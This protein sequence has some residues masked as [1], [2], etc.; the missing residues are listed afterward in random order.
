[1]RIFVVDDEA[2]ITRY[3][4]Q[5]I[6]NAPGKHEVVGTASSGAKALEK[7]GELRPDIL[8]TDITMPKM[9]GLEL[10]RICKEQYP[11]LSVMMLTCH[12]DFEYARQAM[13]DH[14]DD[15]MLKSEIGP[16]FI[17]RKLE[18]LE[19]LRKKRNTDR[20][21]DRIKQ[22]NYIRAMTNAEERSVY[23][24]NEHDLRDSS[25]LLREDAFSAVA[26]SNT[27]QNVDCVLNSLPAEFENFLM[28]PYNENINIL[29]FNIKENA[30]LRGLEEKERYL[31]ACLNTLR[32]RLN[33]YAGRSR[34]FY[35]LAR[36]PMAIDESVADVERQYYGASAVGGMAVEEA[37]RTIQ[38]MIIT[39]AARAEEMD[40]SGCTATIEELL[41][42]A[43]RNHPDSTRLIQ[44]VLQA[45]DLLAQSTEQTLDWSE[46][47]LQQAEGFQAMCG[48]VRK[49]MGRLMQ[50]QRRRY[51]AA[52]GKAVDY[53]GMH[54]GEDLTLNTVADHVFLNREHLS[55]QF[56]KEVGVNFSEYLMELRLREALR[57]LRGTELRI[58]EIADRVGL[59]N[60][61][62]FTSVFKKQYHMTPSEARK[63]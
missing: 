48:L 3:I 17:S 55:R 59:P 41:V 28:Y 27:A 42:F 4:V 62:Y 60:V 12:D 20:M 16:E 58:G 10:L 11:E 21:A 51:S 39:V 15:Y 49:Q 31:T 40:L 8:F 44:T 14:A 29:F 61:S 56:K 45:L 1:M 35:R 5:C 33:G 18:K 43:E 63:Q 57:L 34:V 47:T 19:N 50:Q 32:A 9:D 13:Q 52:I 36:L 54:F 6:Q 30:G 38:R 23:L 26:F 46:G 25:I 22:T 2:L 7:I 37:N 53:I 24:L